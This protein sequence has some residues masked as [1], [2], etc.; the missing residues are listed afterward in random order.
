MGNRPP[1][2]TF[3]RPWCRGSYA[4]GSACG[5]CERCEW[6]RNQIQGASLIPPAE[7][8]DE[9]IVRLEGEL[10][11]AR[12]EIEQQRKWL[13]RLLLTVDGDHMTACE[14]TM[15]DSHPCTC[16]ATEIRLRLGNK[17]AFQ[18][19]DTRNSA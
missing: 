16:G 10:S 1:F 11:A 4:L 8:K 2:E 12:V 3:K 13:D 7:T 9:A 19:K 6:E 14:K 5:H 18:I 17:E 15:G